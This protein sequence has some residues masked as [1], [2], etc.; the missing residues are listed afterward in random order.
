MAYT[1]LFQ[2]PIDKNDS[3][4][5]YC[6]WQSVFAAFQEVVKE[7][8]AAGISSDI[9]VMNMDDFAD[10]HEIPMNDFIILRHFN[11]ED[12]EGNIY[13]SFN[14]GISTYSDGNNHRLSKLISYVYGRYMPGKAQYIVDKNGDVKATMTFTDGTHINYMSKSEMRSTQYITVTALS[15][16]SSSLYP[17]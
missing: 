8:K 12:E 3:E 9:E 5:Y 14:I 15:T 4:L 1:T 16:A 10:I 7:I 13:V 17:D 6:H 2:Q 11:M